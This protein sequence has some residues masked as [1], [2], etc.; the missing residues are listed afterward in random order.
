MTDEVKQI[1]TDLKNE[2]KDLFSAVYQMNIKGI[3]MKILLILVV[4]GSI[5]YGCQYFNKAFGL[6]DDNILEEAVENK[7]KEHTGLDVDLTPDSPE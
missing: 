3:V 4:S 1:W 7:L 2:F 6:D 5:F